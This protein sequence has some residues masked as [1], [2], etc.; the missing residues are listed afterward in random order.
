MSVW[1]SSASTAD[2]VITK[3]VPCNGRR[4]L[5]DLASIPKTISIGNVRITNRRYTIRV[6]CACQESRNCVHLQTVK[7]RFLLKDTFRWRNCSP[8]RDTN[9][10][11]YWIIIIVMKFE[12]RYIWSETTIHVHIRRFIHKSILFSSKAF[13]ST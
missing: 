11:F 13:W 12:L 8:H 6:Y 9:P 3:A 10:L 1:L 4:I 5:R 2:W 7:S